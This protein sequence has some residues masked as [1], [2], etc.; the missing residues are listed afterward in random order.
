ME[1][2]SA[3]EFLPFWSGQLEGRPLLEGTGTA[4]HLF[5]LPDQS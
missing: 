2:W 4:Q 1:L 5:L 3:G